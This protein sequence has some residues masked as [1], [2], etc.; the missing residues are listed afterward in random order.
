MTFVRYVGV[1]VVAY[2]IDLGVFVVLFHGGIAGPIAA[3]V[4]AKVAAGAFAFFAHRAF[5]FRI[6]GT[7][8]V[9]SEAVKYALLLALNVPLASA[10]LALLMT[11]IPVATFAKIAADVVCVGLTFL[12]TRH[13]VFGRA[14]ARPDER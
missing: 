7:E 8:R 11:A 12:L 13:G 2:A 14:A 4:A 5:T 6:A 9:R 3:N 10:L 1:Q